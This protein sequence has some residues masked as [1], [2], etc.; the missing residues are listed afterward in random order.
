MDQ[1]PFGAQGD[2]G[3]LNPLVSQRFRCRNGGSFIH[4]LDPGQQFGLRFVRGDDANRMHQLLGQRL[5]R[6]RIQ[7]QGD[8]MLPRQGGN[9]LD[10]LHGYFQLDQDEAEP[11]DILDP[12]YILSRDAL[13]GAARHDNTVLRMLI[14]RNQGHPGRNLLGGEN[15]TGIKPFLFE[16]TSG[17]FAIAVF[18]SLAAESDILSQPRSS[19]RLVG[20]FSSRIEIEGASQHSLSRFWQPFRTNHQIRIGTSNY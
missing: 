2:N 15:I 14:H 18:S 7:D 10:R 16:Q 12:V 8:S 5:G 20:T 4:D 3:S 17:L 19:H 13:I 6:C 1:C 9:M 11:V